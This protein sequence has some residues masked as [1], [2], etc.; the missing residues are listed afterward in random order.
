LGKK[1]ITTTDRGPETDT[2]DVTLASESVVRIG[3]DSYRTEGKGYRYIEPGH[4]PPYCRR[5]EVDRFYTVDMHA[6]RVATCKVAL[7]KAIIEFPRDAFWVH[8]Q[9]VEPL[10]AGKDSVD[11]ETALNIVTVSDVFDLRPAGDILEPR[12]VVHLCD[13]GCATLGAGFHGTHS[14]TNTYLDNEFFTF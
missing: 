12:H 7:V 1:E 5:I 6:P 2:N 13:A 10:V 9:W 4:R 14:D 8:I 3:G 11:E